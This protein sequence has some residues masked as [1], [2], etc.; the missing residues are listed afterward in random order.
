MKKFMKQ[1]LSL[2]ASILTLSSLVIP[3][4][5]SK[6]SAEEGGYVKFESKVENKGEAIDGGTLRY[7]LV[8]SPFEGLLNNMMYSG[9]PDWQIINFMNPSLYGYDEN[10]KIDDSGFAKIELNKD[11]KSVTISIPK[12]AK[13]SDGEP[14][15][16]DDV[17]IPYYIIGSKDY[18]GIR[19]GE[20][21][22]NVVGM[23]DYHEGKTDE[24]SGLERID[25]HTLKVHYEV[26]NNSMQI[27]G[28]SISS[29]IEPNHI[30]KDIPVKD[31]EDSEFVRSKPVGFGPYKLESLVPG[32]SAT[33]I[34][35]EH[36]YKGKPKI[37]KIQIEVVNPTSAVAEMNAGNYDIA[38]LPSDQY[39]TFKD[40]KNYKTLGVMENAYNYIGF[41]FGTWDAEKNEVKPDEKR[42]VSNKA[43]RQAM[44]YAVDNGAIAK[45]FYDG[46]RQPANSPIPPIFDVYNKD[47]EAYTYNPEKAKELLEKAGFK[48]S[49]GDGFV[50]DPNGK[51]FKLGF[52][53]MSGGETAEPIAQYYMQAWK[54]IGI[55][56]ELVDGRLLEF[57][58]FYDRIDKDDPAID[59]YAAAQGVG[60][61][62]NP[63]AMYARNGGFNKGRWANE[64]NDKL[65][66]DIAS[67]KSF[68]ENFRK[69]SFKKWQ[70]L[71]HEEVPVI[72][73]LFRHSLVSVNNRVSQY[74]IQIGSDLDWTEIY[75]TAD[76]PVK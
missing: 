1:G 5:T 16:I 14:I 26:F 50:E 17:I 69:E 27:A 23:K 49:N 66:A 9:E 76:K 19:Y 7:A 18:T 28:G 29:Y 53:S 47:Q 73:T 32:E 68:D 12:D 57:N 24:I 60:G 67:D 51:E 4:A 30:L 61:D 52:A 34:A 64:E 11:E 38:S 15:V 13:W 25:D 44:A 31:L 41:K 35:N 37:E 8:G 46:I 40:A 20:D 59:V 56:V 63:S 65:L 36:Y 75:L 33:L 70:A 42:V 22:E 6:V 48:D 45:E 3:T 2:S 74:D 54:E 21:F 71:I 62:P 10:F 58:S 55:N 39:Q 43:L 72:P